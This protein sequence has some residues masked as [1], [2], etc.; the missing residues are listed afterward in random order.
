MIDTA[1]LIDALTLEL[2]EREPKW[3]PTILRKSRLHPCL[4]DNPTS[5]RNFRVLLNSIEE[6]IITSHVIGEIRSERYISQEL[7]AIYWQHCLNFFDMRNVNEKLVTLRDLN[8]DER[9]KQILCVDGPTD[10]GLIALADR[11]G[12]LLLTNDGHLY[13]WL[14]AFPRMKIK[15][16]EDLISY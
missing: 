12:C 3:E 15:L 6:I 9:L 1:P 5:Q 2:I 10:A 14:G 13:N 4:A 16:V 8:N 7:H 11:E